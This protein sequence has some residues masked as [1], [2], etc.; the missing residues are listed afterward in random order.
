MRYL[1]RGRFMLDFVKAVHSALGIESTRAF[2]MV[3][4]LSFGCVFA[5]IGGGL[6]WI[7]D[8]S[9]KNSPD[10]KAEHTISA[11][12][13]SP[14]KPAE[15]QPKVGI[16]A[17]ATAKVEHHGISSK[18]DVRVKKG[19]IPPEQQKAS[20]PAKPTGCAIRIANASGA[21]IRDNELGNIAEDAICVEGVQGAEVHN[22]KVTNQ[23][24]SVVQPTTSPSETKPQQ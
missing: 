10:Y 22:N 23:G 7:A 1:H 19:T 18:V 12:E 11:P 9:Y 16:Q 3:M 4:A 13:T 20:V 6:G 8:R 21:V 14:P 2:V 5:I 17:D 24:P 15:T